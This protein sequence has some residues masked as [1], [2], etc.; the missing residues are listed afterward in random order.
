MRKLLPVLAV[1]GLLVS[2]AFSPVA[3]VNYDRYYNQF[4]RDKTVT[5]SI[6]EAAAAG[7]AA[8]QAMGYDIQ[9]STPELGTILTKAHPA[10]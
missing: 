4:P 2:C 8:L 1:W 10:L 6:S 3:R 9:A 7:Q 5:A